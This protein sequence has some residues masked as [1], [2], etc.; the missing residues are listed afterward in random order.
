MSSTSMLGDI[1]LEN[2]PTL[3]ECAKTAA[4]IQP[5]DFNVLVAP[6]KTVEKTKGGLILTQTTAENTKDRCQIGRL[7]AMSP[8]AFTGLS[9]DGPY[10]PP[11]VGDIVMF[12][13]FAGG[14]HPGWEP[15]EQIE[16]YRIMKDKDIIAVVKL[17]E[18]Q[19]NG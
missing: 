6:I 17:P 16:H 7:I 8:V 4:S 14:Q 15:K 9:D 18:D 19:T 3:E 1:N 10:D 13:R 11:K 5:H 12:A 2:I